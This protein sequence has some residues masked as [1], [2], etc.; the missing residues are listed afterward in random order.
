ME[1]LLAADWHNQGVTITFSDRSEVY[2]VKP[3]VWKAAGMA[4]FDGCLCIGC[5]ETRIGRIPPGWAALLS[6]RYPARI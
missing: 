5:L 6:Y 4:D 2:M 1:Q 3:A